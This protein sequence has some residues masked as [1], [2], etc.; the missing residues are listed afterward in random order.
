[1][2]AGGGPM[3]WVPGYRFGGVEVGPRVRDN[4]VVI[5][6]RS[7]G[8]MGRGGKARDRRRIGDDGERMDVVRMSGEGQSGI[9]CTLSCRLLGRCQW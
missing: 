4:D 8:R 1:M 6:L 2:K 7:R 9:N 5:K 3:S